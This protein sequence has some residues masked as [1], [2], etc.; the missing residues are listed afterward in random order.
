MVPSTLPSMVSGS[1]LRMSPVMQMVFPMTAP[2][3]INGVA[4]MF[5]LLGRRW[6]HRSIELHQPGF[7]GADGPGKLPYVADGVDS[8][9]QFGEI[10]GLDGPQCR[11]LQLGFVGDLLQG[12]PLFTANGSYA[13]AVRS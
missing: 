10:S 2:G 1:S 13:P 4:D 8:A 9:G 3:V 7:V 11:D 5:L 6:I 12:D